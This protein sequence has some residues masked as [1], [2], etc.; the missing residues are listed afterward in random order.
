[1]LIL[2]L[3][4]AALSILTIA[5]FS[6]LGFNP[7]T[8][9]HLDGSPVLAF[10]VIFAMAL[11]ILL[12][13]FAAILMGIILKRRAIYTGAAIF[14]ALMAMHLLLHGELPENV[15]EYLAIFL[16][17]AVPLSN[18]VLVAWVPS[19]MLWLEEANP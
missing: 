1:M 19:R 3:V 13:P 10:F 2:R 4:I 6:P 7:L 14:L 5:F 16:F 15:S 8:D 12:S 18:L 17:L 11:A 9:G